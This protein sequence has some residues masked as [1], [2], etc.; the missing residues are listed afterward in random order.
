MKAQ[1]NANIIVS[2]FGTTGRQGSSRSRSRSRSRR[3]SRRRSRR[4]QRPY[5]ETFSKCEKVTNW[6]SCLVP[7]Y[8]RSPSLLYPLPT[9]S[10][11]STHPCFFCSTK[12]ISVFIHILFKCGN[13]NGTNTQL[14]MFFFFYIAK[15]KRTERFA[16]KRC[17]KI[18]Y[19]IYI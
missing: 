4:R 19:N 10:L 14:F 13:Q 17:Y 5:T 11:P 12:C 15:Q 2:V 16:T 18:I 3:W 6:P 9:T 8:S 1:L 7:L